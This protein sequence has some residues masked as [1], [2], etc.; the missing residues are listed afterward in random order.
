[1]PAAGDSHDTAAAGAARFATTHWSVVLAAGGSTSPQ[2]AAALEQLCRSYW[3]PLYAFVRRRGHAEPD[4]Q[5]LTQAF[6]A[7]LLERRDLR[8]V[9]RDGGRFRSYLLTS[10]THFLRDEWDKARAAKRGGGRE[11]FSLDAQEAD[12]RYRLEPADGSGADKLFARRW[13]LTTLEGALDRLRDECAAEG[14]TRQWELLHPLLAE[15]VPAG[16][17]DSLAAELNLAPGTVSVTLHRLRKRYRELVRAEVS[18]TIS[19]P[20][21]VDEEM[22]AL[23]AALRG[24]GG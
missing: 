24:D 1:M 9:G 16:T 6:F 8:R 10:L 17:Y 19:N 2:A 3:Y 7:R 23:L 15:D 13:A 22:R 21:E 20:A 5:D 11:I 18:R 12:S 4:A 14:K